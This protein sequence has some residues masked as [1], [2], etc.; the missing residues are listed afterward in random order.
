VIRALLPKVT[1]TAG[2]FLDNILPDIVMGKPVCNPYRP[3]V[4]H[5]DNTSPHM[6]AQKS[7]F[8]HSTQFH[9]HRKREWQHRPTTSTVKLEDFMLRQSACSIDAFSEG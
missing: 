9:M 7:T 2:F 4:L 6:S 5:M 3:V 8:A 1:F